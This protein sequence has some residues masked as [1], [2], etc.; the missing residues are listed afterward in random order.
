MRDVRVFVEWRDMKDAFNELDIVEDLPTESAEP[1]V[2]PITSIPLDIRIPMVVPTSFTAGSGG[3]TGI[4]RNRETLNN[5][6]AYRAWRNTT[7]GTRDPT[8]SVY[9][10]SGQFPPTANG[11]VTVFVAA[12][13]HTG[14]PPSGSNPT[15]VSSTGDR[16]GKRIPD[17]QA[18]F[19][20]YRRVNNRGPRFVQANISDSP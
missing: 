10:S 12:D 3:V 17:G 11:E 15:T 4:T 2:F 8:I 6:T 5:C 9:P 13:N 18:V 14:G 20:H 19:V 1:T 7:G 16:V